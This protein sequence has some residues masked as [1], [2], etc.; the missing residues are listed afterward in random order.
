[1]FPF[2]LLNN[3]DNDDAPA[4]IHS[5][6]SPI[7]ACAAVAVLAVGGGAT[8]ATHE[9]AAST[10]QGLTARS[11]AMTVRQFAEQAVV[12]NDSYTACQYLTPAEQA[13]VAALG[14]GDADCRLTLDEQP[15]LLGVDS[16]GG[17]QR[18]M[19]HS[20]V[21]GRVATVT[22]TKPGQPSITFTL[23]PTTPNDVFAFEA[24]AVSW[25]ISGGV[26]QMLGA[27]APQHVTTSAKV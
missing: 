8:L 27:P 16:N 2:S 7:M 4:P 10:P 1:M 14:G 18:L 20:T 19:L 5:L 12:Q 13:R 23:T 6:R 11:A 17:L 3:D 21:H 25:R 22:A 15:A 9:A 24:P 26:T